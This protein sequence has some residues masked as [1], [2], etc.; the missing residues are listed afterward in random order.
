MSVGRGGGAP[1]TR[2][3]LY[4]YPPLR[5]GRRERGGGKEGFASSRLSFFESERKLKGGRKRKKEARD[6][7]AF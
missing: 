5:R 2:K 7:S 1:R 6:V 4:L 3:V